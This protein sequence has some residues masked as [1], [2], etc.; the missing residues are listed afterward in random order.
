MRKECKAMP[1]YVTLMSFTKKG[2]MDIREMP[3][4]A[5]RAVEMLEEMG[6]KLTALYL[7]MG[8]YD[9]VGIAEWPSDEAAAAYLLKLGAFGNVTTKTLKA[10][11]MEQ[12]G[13][14][15]AMLPEVE[16]DDD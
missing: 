7:L 16:E 9:F 11:T 5:K 13:E 2:I 14:I 10:F 3:E 8:D 12:F 15:V 6:G 4:G 1:T